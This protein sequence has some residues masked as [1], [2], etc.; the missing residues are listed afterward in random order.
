MRRLEPG[1]FQS[2]RLESAGVREHVADDARILQFSVVS[3]ANAKRR[4]AAEEW[5]PRST[6]V[7]VVV[8]VDLSLLDVLAKQFAKHHCINL[9]PRRHIQHD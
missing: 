3:F 1:L 9:T 5:R 6:F 4:Q 7:L 2:E 8:N